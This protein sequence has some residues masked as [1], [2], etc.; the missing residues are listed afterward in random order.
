MAMKAESRLPLFDELRGLAI[1]GVIAIHAAVHDVGGISTPS[2]YWLLVV[3]TMLSRFAVPSFLI[4]SGLFVS[5]KE[6]ASQQV[7]IKSSMIRRIQRVVFPY[8]IWSS[9]YFLFFLLNGVQYSRN[10][11]IIFFEQL[12]TGSVVLHLYFLVLIIQMYVLSYFGFMKNGRAGKVTMLLVVAAFLAFTIPSY[13]LSIDATVLTGKW[14]RAGYYFTAFE[15]SLFPR[16]LLFFMLGRWMGIHWN[17]VKNFSMRH[18][19]LLSLSVVASLILCGLDFYCLRLWSGNIHL[20]PPDWMISCFLF[21]SFFAIWFLTLPVHANLVFEW[22]G[23]LGTVSFGVYLLHE[24]LLSMI[25]RSTYWHSFA[26]V[27]A[28]AFLRQSAAIPVGLG[29]SIVILVVLQRFLPTRVKR[30]VFG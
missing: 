5:Y 15:R 28:N 16:W 1:I 12:L 17:E 22:L 7:V 21:G 23:K 4:I 26:G 20:L 30:Y 18:R 19:R 25:M 29:V 24:P 13:I 6:Q 9:L 2:D 10:P 14:V 3:Q 8:I 11:A 27:L